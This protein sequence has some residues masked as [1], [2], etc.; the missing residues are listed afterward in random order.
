MRIRAERADDAQAV[1]RVVRCAFGRAD[2]ARLVDALRA[3]ASPHV[4]LVAEV[5]GIV[6]G[7][8]LFTPV[9][10]SGHEQLLLMG[11]APLAVEPESQRDGIGSALTRAGLEHCRELGAVGAVVLGHAD[12]YPR[13]G[14]APS[15]DFGIRCEYDVPADHFMVLE[16]TPGALNGATGTIRYHGAFAA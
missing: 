13:F 11:L 9:T 4:S 14:F 6:V 10:L 15:I 5:D 8:V 16:L 1:R 2:E 12:Y 7:H 3:Q